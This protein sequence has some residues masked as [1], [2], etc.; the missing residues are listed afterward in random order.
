MPTAASAKIRRLS[1]CVRAVGLLLLG[2]VLFLY[3]GTWLFPE[4]PFWD[5]HWT[6]LARVG[7]LPV[8][9]AA[10]LEGTNRFLIGAI[11]LPYLACLTFAYRHLDGLLRGFERAQFF[12]PATV[13][14]LRAFAGFLLAA[15]VFSLVANHYRVWL[16]MPVATPGTRPAISITGDEVALLLMCALIFLI[17]HLMEEGNR[18]AE[19]NRG[20]L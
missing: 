5:Q 2:S 20:F 3:L 11:C 6:R 10:A 15:K 4:L 13:A 14:H 1:A 17:G 8:K 7:A 16:Y 12:E 9:A 19:E 18:L